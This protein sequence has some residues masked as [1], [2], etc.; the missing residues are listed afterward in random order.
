MSSVQ[1]NKNVNC[2]TPNCLFPVSPTTTIPSTSASS[3]PMESKEPTPY[4][5]YNRRLG[6]D[7]RGKAFEQAEREEFGGK[8]KE[9]VIDDRRTR[10]IHRSDLSFLHRGFP[11]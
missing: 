10:P 7:H 6:R 8:L 1:K 3:E 2:G 11:D 4:N 5:I 9:A